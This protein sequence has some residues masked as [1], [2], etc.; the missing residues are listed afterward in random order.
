MNNLNLTNYQ[1]SSLLIASLLLS[2]FMVFNY[3]L[4]RPTVAKA[5]DYTFRSGYQLNFG[6]TT[7]STLSDNTSYYFSCPGHLSPGTSWST[8]FNPC[9]VSFGGRITNASVVFHNR[10]TPATSE[11]SDVYLRIFDPHSENDRYCNLGTIQAD[12]EWNFL[13]PDD[14]NSQD[15]CELNPDDY[16]MLVLDTPAWV[17]DPAIPQLSAAIYIDTSETHDITASSGDNIGMTEQDEWKT[18][19]NSAANDLFFNA[20]IAFL[21]SFIV[22]TKI[23]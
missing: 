9:V 15:D 14:L 23:V 1:K 16:L 6:H 4:S 3:S 13:T 21:L 2:L 10:S 12:A 11:T 22:G 18:R 8:G 19:N 17:T 20:S 7:P 5:A